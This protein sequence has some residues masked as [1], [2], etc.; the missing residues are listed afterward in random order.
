MYDSNPAGQLSDSKETIA[1]S[2]SKDRKPFFAIVFV[3]LCVLTALSFWVA[4]SYLMQRPLTGW[5]LMMSISVAKAMLVILFFMH[6]WWEKHWKYVITVPALII[7]V[8]LVLLLIPD[9]GNRF[10]TYSKTRQSAAPAPSLSLTSPS[11]ETDIFIMP[12]VP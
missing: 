3:M 12:N 6:L 8:V 9:V 11:P 7:G 2:H 10:A 1:G 4:N 5:T